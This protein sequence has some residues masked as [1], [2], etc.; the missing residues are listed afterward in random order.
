MNTSNYLD[1]IEE[2]W[3]DPDSRGTFMTYPD[4]EDVWLEDD[5]RVIIKGNHFNL[6]NS[7]D[8]F[9]ILLNEV[10]VK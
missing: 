5:K 3:T 1:F 4:F 6:I 8:N 7:E 9:Q 10:H 2:C